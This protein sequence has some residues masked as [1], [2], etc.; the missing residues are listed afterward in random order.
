M[1]RNQT[2]KQFIRILFINQCLTYSSIKFITNMFGV[3]LEIATHIIIYE[4]HLN[5]MIIIFT[6]SFIKKYIIS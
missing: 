5:R 1:P 2:H 3:K 4:S 6:N